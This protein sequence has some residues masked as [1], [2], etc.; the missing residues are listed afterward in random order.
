MQAQAPILD[1]VS[2]NLAEMQQ[3]KL[4]ILQKKGM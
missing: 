3:N 1:Q 4:P 2:N